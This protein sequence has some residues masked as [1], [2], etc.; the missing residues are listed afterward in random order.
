MFELYGTSNE[1]SVFKDEDC[2][3]IKKG[4]RIYRQVKKRATKQWTFYD[5]RP[6]IERAY[7]HFNDNST[8]LSEFYTD[9]N[10]SPEILTESDGI[11]HL[12]PDCDKI[13][14]IAGKDTEKFCLSV[15]IYER[16]RHAD[17]SRMRLDIIHAICEKVASL[18]EDMVPASYDLALANMA[19]INKLAV[20]LLA[21]EF[22]LCVARS[23]VTWDNVN[24]KIEFDALLRR[25]DSQISAGDAWQHWT[26][27]ETAPESYLLGD[28]LNAFREI[29]EGRAIQRPAPEK[30][31]LDILNTWIASQTNRETNIRECSK[32]L[33][34]VG[35][36]GAGKT[37]VM[38]RIGKHL[39]D[40]SNDVDV[41]IAPG[42]P[43]DEFS[44]FRNV[45]STLRQRVVLIDN[46]FEGWDSVERISDIYLV[47]NLLFVGTASL[48]SDSVEI[49]NLKEK[50]RG[51]LECVE[52]GASLSDEEQAELT[53]VLRKGFPVGRGEAQ[54]IE[55]TNIRHARQI[56]SGQRAEV[57]LADFRRLLYEEGIIQ[58]QLA[59]VLFSSRLGIGVPLSLL[60][61]AFEAAVANKLQAWL[62]KL[63]R[64]DETL[65][66]F[67]NP[68]EAEKFLEEK[69]PNGL[70]TNMAQHYYGEL[71]DKSN[72]N[73]SADR[74]FVRLLCSKLAKRDGELLRHILQDARRK[75]EL[76]IQK[77]PLWAL[78]FCWLPS[79]GKSMSEKL[80]GIAAD[81][82]QSEPPKTIAEFVLWMEVFGVEA[83]RKELS[84]RVRRLPEWNAR[85]IV[86]V[87]AMIRR[88]PEDNRQAIARQFC[89]LFVRLSAATFFESLQHRTAFDLITALL[90]EYGG[91]YV[92]QKAVNKI[93]DVITDPF[94]R[95]Q[96][97]QMNRTESYINL[98]NRTFQQGRSH[99][100]LAITRAL[101]D[102]DANSVLIWAQE[103][104]S[105]S[106]EQ[107]SCLNISALLEL[108]LRVFTSLGSRSNEIATT[109]IPGNILKLAASWAS[110]EDWENLA[111]KY[112]SAVERAESF[113]V[114]ID[115]ISSLLS[116]G[117]RPLQ[118]GP[119]SCCEKF[120]RTAVALLTRSRLVPTQESAK[121][122]FMT[123]GFVSK[124]TWL[125]KAMRLRAETI[126]AGL[127]STNVSLEESDCGGFLQELGTKLAVDIRD[128]DMYSP[129]PQNWT[130]KTSLASIYLNQLACQNCT[131]VDR[132]E[133]AKRI[134]LIW[135]NNVRLFISLSAGLLRLKQ[136]DRAEQCACCIAESGLNSLHKKGLLAI[137]SARRPNI[138]NAYLHLSNILTIGD[139]LNRRIPL[140]LVSWIHQEFVQVTA[141]AERLLHALCRE[142]TLR[143]RLRPYDDVV[144]AVD[145]GV[146]DHLD[147]PETSEPLGA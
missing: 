7:G 93:G 30:R 92:R 19:E 65:V 106:H 20:R 21:A 101:L 118:R 34:L 35:P 58:H 97:A 44:E 26:T 89:S 28:Q 52:V 134:Q 83:A 8:T 11:K 45:Q 10:V 63:Q 29:Q 24:K 46:F 145:R 38:M 25:I 78:A 104:Y 64:R 87:A 90:A 59:A 61:R 2:M 116:T 37:W 82:L 33:L 40:E 3:I 146:E 110:N 81:R 125:E 68:E 117:F 60:N 84:K 111:N 6:F 13:R 103:R 114:P 132:M 14:G 126:L 95:D 108:G 22:E 109:A 74:V 137:A 141:G 75:V 31:A 41:C 131:D 77:E 138:P 62:I 140:W 135:G 96:T 27:I 76:L 80:I 5:L 98:V 99:L 12:D 1:L 55:W 142:L 39:A 124:Q 56:L 133:I 113:H 69:Y 115:R 70:M 67:E 15:I 51:R 147:E 23:K 18:Y 47:P 91:P 66:I 129:L 88:L 144:A 16:E 85:L 17:P 42:L 50:L 73:R 36:H 32:L 121:L 105:Q 119:Q 49:E 53:R 72:P 9:A 4:R 136:I 54:K 86:Q 71:I 100:S 48:V 122:L 139:K 127:I 102:N 123:L 112:V 143:R 128:I 130:E 43:P 94:E 120:L 57:H 107:E 79:F